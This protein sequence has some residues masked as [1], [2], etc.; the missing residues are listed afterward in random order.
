MIGKVRVFFQGGPQEFQLPLV[1]NSIF[2]IGRGRAA[3]LRFDNSPQYSYISNAHCYIMMRDGQY[4]LA[5]G[6]PDGAPSRHGTLINGQRMGSAPYALRPNDEINLG[7]ANVPV[8]IQFLLAPANELRI[9]EPGHPDER[10]T[11]P[12]MASPFAGAGR[13]NSVPPVSYGTPTPYGNINNTDQYG[14]PITR[15]EDMPAGGRGQL[16][17]ANLAVELRRHI[18]GIL[19]TVLLGAILYGVGRL[20]NIEF[21]LANENK[22]LD[23]IR[24]ALAFLNALIMSVTWY[25]ISCGISANFPRLSAR[26]FMPIVLGVG[27]IVF[28]TYFIETN[29]DNEDTILW[30]LRLV[31]AGVITFSL[32]VLSKGFAPKD[33]P[34]LPLEFAA[35]LLIALVAA[36]YVITEPLAEEFINK[37]NISSMSEFRVRVFII[38]VIY[39]GV[40]GV[41]PLAVLKNTQTAQK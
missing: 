37:V 28:S 29:A 5:D 22:S 19:T 8:R 12:R 6:T 21:L 38:G 4:Y 2:T 18:G 14:M 10:P 35:I 7:P 34:K 20:A 41:L 17:G 23:D 16:P 31:Y 30:T 27:V 1:S 24:P 36:D 25:G 32:S 11:Q 15:Y 40:M 9:P 3:Q 39:G 26:T 13:P 33:S